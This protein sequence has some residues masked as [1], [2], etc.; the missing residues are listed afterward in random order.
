MGVEM[1]GWSFGAQFGDLNNDGLLDLYVTNG[2]LSLDRKRSY[3]YDYSK[4]AAGN[5]AIISD[6]ANWPSLQGRTLS[7]HQGKLVWLNNGDGGFA[8]VGRLAG[9]TDRLDGRAV[10]MADFR[11]NGMLDVVVAN[12]RAPL[13]FYRNAVTPENRWI[14][15]DLE[16]RASNRSAIGAQVELF[17]DGKR[18]IQEVSGGSGFSSQ[19]QRWLH[20]GV[21]RAPQTI[22]AEIRWPSGRKQVI[23]APQLNQIHRIT[24]PE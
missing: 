18:Q 1:G 23:D 4:V 24:E 6:A 19:N 17:W 3:W 22:R 11:N 12:Q 21:G 20:F 10:A 15:F 5:E 9:V 13:L 14:Q 16:G 2:F 7:G 8:E